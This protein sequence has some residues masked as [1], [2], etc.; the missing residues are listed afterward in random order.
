MKIFKSDKVMEL[1]QTED[2]TIRQVSI[3]LECSTQTA[4]SL[5]KELFLTNK[6]GRKNISTPKRPQWLYHL[7]GVKHE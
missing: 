7:N 6:V 4:D 1:L 2:M 3:A 5:L